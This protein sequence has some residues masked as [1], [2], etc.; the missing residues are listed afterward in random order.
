MFYT[1]AVAVGLDIFIILVSILMLIVFYFLLVG[2]THTETKMAVVC[3]VIGLG[4]SLFPAPQAV[5]TAL[6]G[7]RLTPVPTRRRSLRRCSRGFE[8]SSLRLLKHTRPSAGDELNLQM[9][10]MNVRS[11]ARKL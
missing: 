4:R 11:L 5:L 7:P 3:L 1:E 6:T 10:L 8:R 2:D 9:A